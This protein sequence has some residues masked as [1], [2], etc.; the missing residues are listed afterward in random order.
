MDAG[1]GRGAVFESIG[2]G[3][4]HGSVILKLGMP[5][6]QMSVRIT[7]RL[8]RDLSKLLRQKARLAD[9]QTPRP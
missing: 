3:V 6:Q 9:N 5:D 1:N 8:A 7:P 4:D 2:V